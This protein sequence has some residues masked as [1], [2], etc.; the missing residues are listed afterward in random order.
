[1]NEINGNKFKV[2]YSIEDIRE[3]I[4]NKILLDWV[5]EHRPDVVEKAT[6]FIDSEFSL[7]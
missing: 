6:N 1:M 4:L 3:F 7:D 2:D 5:K